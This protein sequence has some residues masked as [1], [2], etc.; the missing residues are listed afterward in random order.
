MYR[1]TIKK[2]VVIDK[3]FADEHIRAVIKDWDPT[4]NTTQGYIDQIRERI[5]A[6]PGKRFDKDEDILPFVIAANL[7]LENEIGYALD[8]AWR[9]S[10]YLR[11]EGGDE[12][13]VDEAYNGG[14][15]D[16]ASSQ[17]FLGII[18]RLGKQENWALSVK[19]AAKAAQASDAA[20]RARLI[21]SITQGHDTFQIYAKR[22]GEAAY[23]HTFASSELDHPDVTIDKLREFEAAAADVRRKQNMSAEQRADDLTQRADKARGHKLFRPGDTDSLSSNNLP[24]GAASVTTDRSVPVAETVKQ[25]FVDP[26][27]GQFYSRLALHKLAT[28]NPKLWRTMM[29]TDVSFMNKLLAQAN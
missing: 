20:T 6:T 14:Y 12:M 29:R 11:H 18:N 28:T 4:R 25:L 5:I 7:P 23:L 13:V 2:A 22:P 9:D 21:Q 17:L 27:T 8:A 10:D 1:N 26:T 3:E 16:L 19:G 15:A 24:E